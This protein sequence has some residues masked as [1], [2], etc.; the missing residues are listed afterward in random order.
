MTCNHNNRWVGLEDPQ[1]SKDSLLRKEPRFDTTQQQ[2]GWVGSQQQVGWV[3]RSTRIERF[4]PHL[5]LIRPRALVSFLRV[6]LL[7]EDP[8]IHSQLNK[9]SSVPHIRLQTSRKVFSQS[10][11]LFVDTPEERRASAQEGLCLRLNKRGSSTITST[12]LMQDSRTVWFFLSMMDGSDS[13]DRRRVIF[14][15][16]A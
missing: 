16:R 14:G 4:T 12:N 9:L 5:S 3:G 15:V 10:S 2:V 1:G 8:L 13:K 6:T 7:Q 11:L